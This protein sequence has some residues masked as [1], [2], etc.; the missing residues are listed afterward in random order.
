MARI[1]LSLVIVALAI[2]AQAGP[3]CTRRKWASVEECITKCSSRWG[4]AGHAMGN[5]PWGSVVKIAQ[6][7][8]SVDQLVAEACGGSSSMYEYV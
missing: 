7:D 4:W 1:S 8:L 5:D 6:N 3:A 2:T